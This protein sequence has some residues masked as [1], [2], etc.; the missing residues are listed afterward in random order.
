MTT[1]QRVLIGI[2][3]LFLIVAMTSVIIIGG[4]FKDHASYT[5][6]YHATI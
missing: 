1:K 4:S 3:G 6:I 2:G 5:A